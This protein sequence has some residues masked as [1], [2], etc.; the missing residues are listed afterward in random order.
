MGLQDGA[1]MVAT[2]ISPLRGDNYTYDDHATKITP[3]W[4]D[5]Y[6][7]DDHTTMIMPRWGDNYTLQRSRP[8]GA[9]RM[10]LATEWRH[11]CSI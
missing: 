2:K 9:T 8:D 10:F 3:R 1:P 5:N 7:Y 11:L 6:S 4:G